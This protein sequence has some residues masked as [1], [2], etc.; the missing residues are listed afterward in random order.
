MFAGLASLTLDDGQAQ[1]LGMSSREGETISFKKAISL[2]VK[3]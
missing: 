1:I 2:K 3:V